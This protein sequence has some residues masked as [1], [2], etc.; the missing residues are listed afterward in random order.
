MIQE[1]FIESDDNDAEEGSDV[2]LDKQELKEAL[3]S[4]DAKLAAIDIVPKVDVDL[5]SKD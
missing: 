2:D 1:S 5:K 4:R 3:R